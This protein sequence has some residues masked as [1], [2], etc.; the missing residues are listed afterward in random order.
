MRARGGVA[1]ILLLT[2]IL[3]CTGIAG[4]LSETVYGQQPRPWREA[5]NNNGAP[6]QRQNSLQSIRD[7]L[8]EIQVTLEIMPK[9]NKVTELYNAKKFKQAEPLLKQVISICETKLGRS[10]AA[11][12]KLP[13]YP[14]TGGFLGFPREANS[15]SR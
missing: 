3:S 12:L 15:V 10:H 13:N 4:T 9:L 5:R 1:N 7:N 14:K 11:I 6:P 2:V 8:R